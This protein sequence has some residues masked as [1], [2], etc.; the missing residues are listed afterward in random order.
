MIENGEQT[1]RIA[2]DASCLGNPGMME[3][4]GVSV[5]T[6]KELFHFGPVYATNNIGEFLALV[7]AMALI[8]NGKLPYNATIYSDS[9]TA[10][11]WVK[12][13]KACSK[14]KRVNETKG[15]W[16]IV[17]RAERWLEDNRFVKF[18]IE[19]WNKKLY[20]EIPADFGRKKI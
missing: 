19:K 20:G 2:V 16:E 12:K 5:S 15:I 17:R 1:Y 14:L 4:R 10:I 7:H 11:S 6:G 13:R 18:N 3:Y 8:K 9:V